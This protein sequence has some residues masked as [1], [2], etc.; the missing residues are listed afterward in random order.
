MPTGE[1]L[2]KAQMSLMEAQD[3]LERAQRDKDKSAEAVDVEMRKVRR[4]QVLT[5]I[6]QVEYA[7]C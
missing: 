4:L 3:E 1:A 6:K 7:F 5:S 2:Q